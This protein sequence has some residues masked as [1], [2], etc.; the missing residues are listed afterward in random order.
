MVVEPLSLVL[1]LRLPS[2]V[3]MLS[4]PLFVYGY[5]HPS[6]VNMLVSSLTGLLKLTF[7]PEPAKLSPFSES[8]LHTASTRCLVTVPVPTLLLVVRVMS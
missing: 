6:M 1:M 8:A 4:A 2:S 5:I 7:S 3:L